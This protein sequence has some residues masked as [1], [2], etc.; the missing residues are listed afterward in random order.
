MEGSRVDPARLLGKTYSFEH[1]G[2]IPDSK[3]SRNSRL[4]EGRHDLDVSHLTHGDAELL[5]ERSV[6]LHLGDVALPEP[7]VHRSLMIR[8]KGTYKERLVLGAAVFEYYRYAGV[9]WTAFQ[10]CNLPALQLERGRS[11]DAVQMRRQHIIAI[12]VYRRLCC[13]AHGRHGH[14]HG[15]CGVRQHALREDARRGTAPLL[16]AIAEQT[17]EALTNTEFQFKGTPST[18]IAQQQ[19]NRKTTHMDLPQR[20]S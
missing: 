12:G 15:H 13:E 8:T 17:V 4:V 5:C 19:R 3:H 16:K 10:L 1:G 20:L 14:V 7:S 18:Q 2:A 11:Q 6:D 9:S